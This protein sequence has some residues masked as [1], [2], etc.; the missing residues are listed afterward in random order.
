MSHIEYLGFVVRHDAKEAER[1]VAACVAK[2]H[3]RGKFVWKAYPPGDKAFIRILFVTS[4]L[5]KQKL[6]QLTNVKGGVPADKTLLKKPNAQ[7]DFI[8][9]HLYDV[10]S[11]PESYTSLPDDLRQAVRFFFVLYGQ[12]TTIRLQAPQGGLRPHQIFFWTRLDFV[13]Q[14]DKQQL[15]KTPTEI[16]VKNDPPRSNPNIALRIPLLAEKV[17]LYLAR[18]ESWQ[19]LYKNALKAPRDLPIHQMPLYGLQVNLTQEKEQPL[20]YKEQHLQLSEMIKRHKMVLLTGPSGSGKTTIQ[21]MLVADLLSPVAPI[22]NRLPIF[23]SLKYVGLGGKSVTDLIVDSVLKQILNIDSLKSTIQQQIDIRRAHYGDIINSHLLISTKGSKKQMAESLFAAEVREF[24]TSKEQEGSNEIIL[25]LDGFNEIPETKEYNAKQEIQQL[26][27]KVDQIVVS[28]RSYGAAE[29]LSGF[30]RFQ[31]E[32]LSDQQIIGYLNRS[33][34]GKEEEFFDHKI[35]TNGRILS[36]ARV[37]FY[38]ELI[39]KYHQKYPDRRLPTCQGPLLQFFVQKQYEKKQDVKSQQVPKITEPRINNFLSK[40][41]HRLIDKGKGNPETVLSF[42]G[43]VSA[44]LPSFTMVELE[45]TAK[46]AELFGFLEKS[47]Q[48]SEE[49]GAAGVIS[50]RHDNIRDYFAAIELRSK[51]VLEDSAQMKSYL[52]HTKWDNSWLMLYGT[53]ESEKQFEKA[54]LTLGKLDPI[55]ASHCLT[56]STAATKKC[57]EKLLTYLDLPRINILISKDTVALHPSYLDPDCAIMPKL[58]PALSRIYSFYPP[59]DLLQLYFQPSTDEVIKTIILR[60]LLYGSNEDAINYFEQIIQRQGQKCPLELFYVLGSC[61]S[62]KAY[63]LLADAYIDAVEK[64]PQ[65]VIHLSQ[66]LFSFR[67]RIPI[68]FVTHAVAKYQKSLK[69]NPSLSNSLPSNH[70]VCPLEKGLAGYIEDWLHLR[71]HPN[72]DISSAA[73]K[74]LLRIRHPALIDDIIKECEA[75]NPQDVGIWQEEYFRAFLNSNTPGAKEIL[76]R[77]FEQIVS[78][79]TNRGL[80]LNIVPLLLEISDKEI[81]KKLVRFGLCGTD[82]ISFHCLSECLSKVPNKVKEIIS[83]ETKPQKLSR[84]AN[85]RTILA[86]T[87]TGDNNTKDELLS[88]FKHIASVITRKPSMPKNE[89]NLYMGYFNCLSKA[90]IA[91]NATECESFLEG[92]ANNNPNAYFRHQTRWLLKQLAL[93][94]PAYNKDVNEL[95]AEIKSPPKTLIEKHQLSSDLEDIIINWPISKSKD[96]LTE[97]RQITE[98]AIEKKDKEKSRW[99]YFVTER[100]RSVYSERLLDIFAGWPTIPLSKT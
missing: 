55:F 54:L 40:V 71:N 21:K 12:K 88:T 74:A 9:N 81:I 20:L 67:G 32:E 98:Q 7:F 51:K 65:L 95:V 37:P 56:V 43:E 49:L 72:E 75:L 69:R 61:R 58:G 57:A 46:A 26:S 27:E 63:K 89:F 39:V 66:P 94:I 70:L 22:P 28:S 41:A 24:F 82:W 4:V 84:E 86:R 15:P 83:S 19:K 91:M 36:M 78:R 29:L 62:P 52:E 13:E 25:F 44:I 99:F 100:L 96:L 48:I 8:L 16:S 35:A 3:E 79:N 77:I 14:T 18:P 45:E 38:L 5:V 47:G 6:A 53:L 87:L 10:R 42:P 97:M 59:Q 17:R 60:A 85:R 33:L 1:V 93:D 31:L 34:D 11:K 73:W 23:V 64:R 90:A 76:F 80:V 2:L 30:T 68:K 50:F 92:I